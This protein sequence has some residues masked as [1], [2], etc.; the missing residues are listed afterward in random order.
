MNEIISRNEMSA[1]ALTQVEGA[2]L[3]FIENPKTGKIFFACGNKQGYISPKVLDKHSSGNLSIDD[4]KY[5]E[6]ST[7]NG[8]TWVPCL[9]MVS[10]NNVV[11]S[12]K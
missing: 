3:N 12:F 5:A 4:M 6:C 7:D 2:A 1:K 9:M 10:S 8:T 11:A